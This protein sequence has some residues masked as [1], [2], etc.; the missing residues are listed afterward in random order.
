MTT[1]KR[2]HDGWELRECGPANAEHTVMLLPGGMCS[3][4]FYEDIMAEPRSI[5]GQYLS[6]VREIAVPAERR[7]LSKKNVLRVIGATGN[8]LKGVTAE[9]PQGTF[10]CITGVSGGATA[11]V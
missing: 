6:G 9:I 4:E 3:G 1:T 7:P 8:N 2:T 10:T 11:P 5:T